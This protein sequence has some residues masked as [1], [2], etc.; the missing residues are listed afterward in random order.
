MILHLKVAAVKEKNKTKQNTDSKSR[1]FLKGFLN[2]TLCMSAPNHTITD[3]SIM[4][5]RLLK[6]FFLM[7]YT[8]KCYFMCNS[9]STALA[10]LVNNLS[11]MEEVF[12]HRN[13]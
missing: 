10:D 5:F 12:K 6:G 9:I 1:L 11:Y 4:I 8:E 3:T 7:Y 13:L 2:L